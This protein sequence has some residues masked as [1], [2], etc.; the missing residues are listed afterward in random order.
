ML[1]EQ[2]S[3]YSFVSIQRQASDKAFFL[4]SYSAPEVN[5]F[6]TSIVSLIGY[7]AGFNPSSFK[8]KSVSLTFLE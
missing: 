5:L 1:Q 7:N 8:F 4:I 6:L 3:Y 2:V